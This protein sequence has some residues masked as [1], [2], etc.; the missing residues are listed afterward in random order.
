MQTLGAVSDSIPEIILFAKWQEN[1]NQGCILVT[2]S[3]E[4]WLPL[5]PWL[6]GEHAEPAPDTGTLKKALEEW[7]TKAP[8]AI[9]L[10]NFWQVKQKF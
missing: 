4:D 1:G 7:K 3:L 9:P 10:T 8:K 2:E 6:K 5:G